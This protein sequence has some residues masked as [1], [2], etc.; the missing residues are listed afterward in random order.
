MSFLLDTNV[1]SELITRRP[2][3]NVIRWVEDQDTDTI[4]L[5]VITVGE[6]N[7]GIQR[8]PDSRRKKALSNWL[9]GDLLVRFADRILPLDVAV[10]MI[11]GAL[12]ARME[13]RGHL[14]P[15]IDSLLAATAAEHGLI[16]AT[17]NVHDFKATDISIL[18]PWE[19]PS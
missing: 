19:P 10:M 4:F 8:L 16:V 18:N 2:D 7:R 5:S 14:I 13:A 15:A 9:I 6:L 17:R 11:W 12:V 1:V 3:P